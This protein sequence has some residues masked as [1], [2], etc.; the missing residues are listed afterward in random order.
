[1]Y[2]MLLT[3]IS[4][5]PVIIT[6]KLSKIYCLLSHKLYLIFQV[7]SEGEFQ[8]SLFIERN[9]GTEKQRHLPKIKELLEQDFRFQDQDSLHY[10]FI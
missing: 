7:L 4:A 10:T 9:L 3:Q 1:M 2:I 5:P 8:H 6:F